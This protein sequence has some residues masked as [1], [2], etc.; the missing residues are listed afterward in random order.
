MTDDLSDFTREDFEQLGYYVYL[1]IDPF[2]DAPFYVGKGKN[3]RVD[4]HRTD[5][6]DHPLAARLDEIRARGGFPRIEI[7]AYGLDEDTAFKVEAAAIDLIGFDNLTN[8]QIGHGAAQYGRQSIDALGTRF[9][10]E[11]VTRLEHNCLALRID[12]SADKAR[13]PLE[14]RFD[15]ITCPAAIAVT[16]GIPIASRTGM[17]NTG[18]SVPVSAEQNPTTA[19]AAIA[20]AAGRCSRVADLRERKNS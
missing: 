7:L 2:T 10:R 11:P 3:S 12:R 19:P 9:A 4:H 5:K 14:S 8:R 18:P 17:R 1:Y 13:E 6:G 15:G 20:I 16:A